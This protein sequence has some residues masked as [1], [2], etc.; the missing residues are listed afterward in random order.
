MILP[1]NPIDNWRLISQ[2]KQAQIDKDVICEYSTR[3]YHD[4]R[5]GDWVMVREK[6]TLN[7][8]YHLK[9]RVKNFKLG[10]ME[11]LQFKWERSHID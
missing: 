4:Y 2:R 11:T 1:I 8:E 6:I 3:V 10:K 7:T 5:I 9:V